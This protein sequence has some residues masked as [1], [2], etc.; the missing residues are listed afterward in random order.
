RDGVLAEVRARTNTQVFPDTRLMAKRLIAQ[1]IDEAKTLAG[2]IDEDQRVEALTTELSGQY[3]FAR[4]EGEVIRQLVALDQKRA[5]EM[6]KREAMEGAARGAEWAIARVGP[7]PVDAARI[8][9][10]KLDVARLRTIHRV[11]PDFPIRP[12]IVRSLA[13]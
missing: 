6:A 4:M 2:I 7:V 9:V 3:V 8:D 13:T 5:E 1:Y 11:W 10:A 12:C